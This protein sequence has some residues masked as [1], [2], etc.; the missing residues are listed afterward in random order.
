MATTASPCSPSSSSSVARSRSSSSP[1]SASC[2]MPYSEQAHGNAAMS[3][4][5]TGTYPEMES[6]SS[7]HPPD[8]PP[9]PPPHLAPASAIHNEAAVRHPQR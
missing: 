9:S 7:C 6:V 1:A 2:L 8:L 3:S 4:I 5:T